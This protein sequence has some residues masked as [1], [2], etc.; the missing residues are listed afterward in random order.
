M[1]KET[2]KLIENTI[3]LFIVICMIASFIYWFNT[4]DIVP[5]CDNVH[6]KYTSLYFENNKTG[7]NYWEEDSIYYNN[8]TDEMNKCLKWCSK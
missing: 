3:F 7:G 6:H 8:F 5:L 4:W 1:K 2:K